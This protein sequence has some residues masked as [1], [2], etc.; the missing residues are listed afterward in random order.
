MGLP[1]VPLSGKCK[2]YIE[3]WCWDKRYLHWNSGKMVG[4]QF[5]VQLVKDPVP[6]GRKVVA[7]LNNAYLPAP[8]S[9]GAASFYSRLRFWQPKD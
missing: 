5:M 9:R 8:D 6:T 2:C 7:L 4:K 3:F 1:K